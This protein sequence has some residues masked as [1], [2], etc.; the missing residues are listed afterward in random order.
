M[1]LR[2]HVTILGATAFGAVTLLGT[3]V[4][5]AGTPSTDWGTNKD[6]WQVDLRNDSSTSLPTYMSSLF[7]NVETQS[8]DLNADHEAHV[9]GRKSWLI[10]GPADV[11]FGFRKSDGAFAP[12]ITVQVRSFP[13]RH[14][15]QVPYADCVVMFAPH[16]A[17]A[18]APVK[19]NEPIQVVV[20]D[21]AV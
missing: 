21:K 15:T 19:T 16:L 10:D 11:D 2:R 7:G 20:F 3:G 6:G 14:H 4:A 9:Y 8:G 5:H 12:G 1:N 18:L 13:A 17:C